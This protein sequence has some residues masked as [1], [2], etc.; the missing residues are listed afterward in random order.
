VWSFAV[1]VFQ[2]LGDEVAQAVLAERYAVVE[3]FLFQR[4]EEPLDERIAVG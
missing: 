3:A 4:P 1:I 2:V